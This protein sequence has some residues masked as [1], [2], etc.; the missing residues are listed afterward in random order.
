MLAGGARQASDA[1]LLAVLIGTGVRGLPVL[2]LAQRLLREVDGIRGLSGSDPAELA[3]LQGVGP[4]RA[5]RVVA[6]A[7]LGRRMLSAP[8]GRIG[9]LTM[10]SEVARYLGP[11]LHG[12]ARE[13]FHALHLDA[14]NCVV[15]AE[16]VS[17]GTLTA[18]LVHPREVFRS[19]VRAGA[20]ALIVVHNHPSGDPEPSEEDR[21]ITRR[22][23]E[24]GDLM[25]IPLV[26]HV[27]VAGERWVSFAERGW[28]RRGSGA[29]RSSTRS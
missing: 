5:A 23:A 2:E 18:S 25:G 12:L 6:A 20:A 7:E 26:D 11:R 15:R 22:L 17:Q 13:Q 27:V 28:L 4:V 24:A 10:A 9:P 19:A 16:L 1:D 29:A 14:R 8:L 3:S 21:R